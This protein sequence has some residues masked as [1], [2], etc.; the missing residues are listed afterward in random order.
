[1][2]F[3]ESDDPSRP[4]GDNGRL[5]LVTDG[6]CAIYLVMTGAASVYGW[7]SAA[8]SDDSLPRTVAWYGDSGM[9][10]SAIRVGK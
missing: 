8:T 9:A 6:D 1:M 5:S 2:L 7:W 3:G 4:Y 10:N